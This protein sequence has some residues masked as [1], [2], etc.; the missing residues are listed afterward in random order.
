M[1]ERLNK[2]FKRTLKPVGLPRGCKE[3]DFGAMFCHASKHVGIRPVTYEFPQRIYEFS[4]SLDEEIDTFLAS[5]DCDR[6][7]ENYFDPV[8][9]ITCN[10][11]ITD[12][13]RQAQAH[14]RACL[15]IR[16]IQNVELQRLRLEKQEVEVQIEKN[17][18]EEM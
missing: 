12:I 1:R 18:R 7:N 8:I 15:G 16:E 3:L 10:L 14:K 9:N 4:K 2:L 13:D 5:V 17:R 6:Y 11:G